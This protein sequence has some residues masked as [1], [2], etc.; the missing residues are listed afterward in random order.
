MAAH[1]CRCA[2]AWLRPGAPVQ[3]RCGEGISE[4]VR[5]LIL[6]GHPAEGANTGS[7]VRAN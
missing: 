6:H 1:G 7:V 2:T 3:K 5:S 4:E